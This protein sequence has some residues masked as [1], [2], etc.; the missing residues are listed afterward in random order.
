MGEVMPGPRREVPGWPRQADPPGHLQ[1]SPKP[2]G[3]GSGYSLAQA[4]RFGALFQVPWRA[5]LSPV[6]LLSHV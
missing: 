6:Q 1:V 4:G 2:G 5:S 3:E